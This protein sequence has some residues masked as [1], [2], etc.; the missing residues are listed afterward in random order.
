MGWL[1]DGVPD[2]EHEGSPIGMLA[3][4]VI[5]TYG[6]GGL[7]FEMEFREGSWSSGNGSGVPDADPAWLLPVCVCGWRGKRAAYDEQAEDAARAQWVAHMEDVT[8]Y[9]LTVAKAAEAFVGMVGAARA[10]G[11]FDG[12]PLTV[13]KALRVTQARI[14]SEIAVAV[15]AARSQDLSWEAIGEALGVTRQTAHERYRDIEPVP[16]RPQ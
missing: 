16:A 13:I 14:V 10:G 8:I 7:W 9:R 15:G 2:E 6:T 12:R 5:P 11:E 1:Y 4:E 3:N